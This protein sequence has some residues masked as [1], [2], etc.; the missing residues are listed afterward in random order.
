MYAACARR[1]NTD[2]LA[3]WLSELAEVAGW[4]AAV[5][6]ASTGCRLAPLAQAVL[7]LPRGGQFLALALAIALALAL[8]C[9]QP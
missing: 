3:D 8:A 6:D 4:L 2:W 7:E 5:R 9:P 1:C